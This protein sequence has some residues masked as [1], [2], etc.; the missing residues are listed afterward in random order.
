MQQSIADRIPNLK[1]LLTV[2]KHQIL[3]YGLLK[4]LA[5]S[6]F[7]VLILYLIITYC[8]YETYNIDTTIN[9]TLFY[10]SAPILL[11]DPTLGIVIF[12]IIVG[13]ISSFS[14]SRLLINIKTLNDN[15]ESYQLEQGEDEEIDENFLPIK[16]PNSASLDSL[17]KWYAKIKNELELLKQNNVSHIKTIN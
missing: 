15:F 1:Y 10:S 4:G 13:T 7:I 2:T 6:A 16:R 12:W 14:K 11:F 8:L 3:W 5:W 9:T 17:I